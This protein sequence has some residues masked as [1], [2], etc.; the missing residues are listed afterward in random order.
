MFLDG[1]YF[2]F[3]CKTLTFVHTHTLGRKLFSVVN[4][5]ITKPERT[6][7]KRENPIQV[8]T[9]PVNIDIQVR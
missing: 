4:P 1:L 5:T 2:E 8:M 3:S 7:S 6:L 9:S